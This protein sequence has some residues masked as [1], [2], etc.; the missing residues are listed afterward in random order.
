MDYPDYLD[1]CQIPY[2]PE[3]RPTDLHIHLKHF[4]DILRNS[5]MESGS[6]NNVLFITSISCIGVCVMCF[7]YFACVLKCLCKLFAHHSLLKN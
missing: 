6:L 7:R 1:C 5:E 3:S 4:I 2:F